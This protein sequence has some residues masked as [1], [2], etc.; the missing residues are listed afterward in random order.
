[1]AHIMDKLLIASDHG[2]Y[3]LKSEIINFLKSSSVD[4]EDLGCHS[5]DSVD[6]P[7]YASALAQKISAGTASRGILVCGTGIGVAITANKFKGVRAATVG[8]V[9]SAKMTRAHNNTNV[10]CLGERVVG[11][12]LALEIV[13]AYLNASFEGGRH[14][15]RVDKISEIESKNFK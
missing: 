7:D 1:M 14:A 3:L 5:R 9:F 4:F 10:L 12:G 13:Q 2:G 15:L 8:D 11:V 6:Y